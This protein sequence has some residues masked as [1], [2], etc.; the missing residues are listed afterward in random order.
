[1]K[2]IF[3]FL[4]LI[5]SAS[6]YAEEAKPVQEKATDAAQPTHVLC[7]SGSVVRR[8]RIEKKKSACLVTYTKEGVEKVVGRSMADDLCRGV[9]DQI[10][11]NLEKGNWKCK[12]ITQSR[13]S[14]SVD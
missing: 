5:F 4:T 13:V 10:K 2:L 6:I 9:F 14:S 7:K 11:N 8:V 1:M 3:L 12:D